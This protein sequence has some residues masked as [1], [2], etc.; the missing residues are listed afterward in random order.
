MGE[1]LL[2]GRE[3]LEWERAAMERGYAHLL[4][5]DMEQIAGLRTS[6]GPPAERTARPLADVI[7]GM[8]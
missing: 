7:T 1:L 6:D 2:N 5:R 4:E 8:L 3:P